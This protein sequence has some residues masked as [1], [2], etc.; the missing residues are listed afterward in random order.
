MVSLA[1]SWKPVKK[2]REGGEG[3]I[4]E[5]VSF[6]N[7]AY[8][9]VKLF[10]RLKENINGLIYCLKKKK[11]KNARFFSCGIYL[12]MSS[13]LTSPICHWLCFSLDRPSRCIIDIY[14][15]MCWF[16]IQKIFLLEFPHF[17]NMQDTLPVS[18]RLTRKLINWCFMFHN[19]CCHWCCLFKYF[20]FYSLFSSHQIT[21]FECCY[22]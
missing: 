21:Q 11:K 5:S 19:G 12:S 17:D 2:R 13:F 15:W 6:R 18:A 8:G 7:Q 20:D 1:F 9:T 16:W 14:R 4:S 3:E 22:F 10:W